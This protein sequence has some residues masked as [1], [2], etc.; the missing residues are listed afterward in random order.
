[1][2]QMCKGK[3]SGK[4]SAASAH[5]HGPTRL[6]ESLLSAPQSAPARQVIYTDG[7][8]QSR[9]RH[10][11]PLWTD[12]HDV[13]DSWCFAV[14]AEQYTEDT[15]QEE[16]QLEFIGLTCQ[17]VLYE[18]D[19]HHHIGTDHIGSDAA[20]TEARLAQNHRIPT[21]YVTDSQLVGGQAQ[22]RVGSSAH[23]AP[24]RNL[25][26]AFQSKLLKLSSQETISELPTH[27]VMQGNPST[28]LSTSSPSW[29]DATVCICHDNRSIC[30]HLVAF[31]AFC[32]LYS[33]RTEIF[34][35]YAKEELPSL[36]QKS[37]PPW[38][39]RTQPKRCTSLTRS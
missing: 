20:E 38:S 35:H 2:W 8:S 24:Y 10:C 30:K 23:N 22:G 7:S 3:G 37:L 34:P 6:P 25:R 14:F 33:R 29:R 21:I 28:S 26:A 32:G 13:S 31:Y 27:A 18:P 17:Q 4:A 12:L 16:R 36:L 15:A 11:S 19:R 5:F 9:K 39:A 1:M